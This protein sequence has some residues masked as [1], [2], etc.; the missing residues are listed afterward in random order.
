M[1]QCSTIR[2]INYSLLKYSFYCSVFWK[3]YNNGNVLISYA[4][5]LPLPSNNRVSKHGPFFRVKHNFVSILR[6]Q[7]RL[8]PVNYF[9]FTCYQSYFSLN[10]FPLGVIL[11]TS[12]LTAL[13]FTMKMAT[14]YA[15][16]CERFTRS[17]RWYKNSWQVDRRCEWHLRWTTHVVSSYLT[18][19]GEDRLYYLLSVTHL[20]AMG[21]WELP[22]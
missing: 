1:F 3:C 7:N 22:K 14:D 5:S 2:Y 6:G 9:S 19:I 4:I 21:R 12:V 18:G 13:S 11:T 16:R 10:C 15:L 17:S 20:R 8:L